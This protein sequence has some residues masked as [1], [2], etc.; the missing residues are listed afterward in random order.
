VVNFGAGAAE[1]EGSVHP[2]R[3]HPVVEVLDGVGGLV[4]HRLEL[5]EVD[6][7]GRLGEVRLHGLAEIA[8][9]GAEALAEPFEL[10]RTLGRGGG[11]NS[12]GV[13]LLGVEDALDVVGGG[14]GQRRGGRHGGMV[15]WAGLTQ[16]KSSPRS[17]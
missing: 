9:V 12:G 15:R 2:I 5:C 1:E 17:P 13:G 16:F 7:R 6:L 14:G 4:E 8:P 3:G 11:A 10:A